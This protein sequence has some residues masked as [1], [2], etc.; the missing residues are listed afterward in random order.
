MRISRS[1]LIAQLEAVRFG[2]S[3][4]NIVEQSSCIVFD[5]DRMFSFNDETACWGPSCLTVEKPLPVCA[6][7]LLGLLPKL[8]D[9]E[10]E[11][12]VEDAKLILRGGNKEFEV[13]GESEL[14]LPIDSVPEPGN[15][16][17]LPPELLEGLPVVNECASKDDAMVVLTMIHFTDKFV[18][19]YDNDQIARWRVKC[20]AFAGGVLLRAETVK[21]I[22]HIEPNEVSVDEKWVFFRQGEGG[23]MVGCRRYYEDYQNLTPLMEMADG[24]EKAVL[25][26]GLGQAAERAYVFAQENADSDDVEVKLGKGVALVTGEGATGRYR[27]KRKI[28]Y[29]GPMVTFRLS[30]T[31]LV[32]LTKDFS[33]C[34]V[35]QTMIR[36]KAGRL[37]Y[38]VSLTKE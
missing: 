10:L 23:V 15:W 28:T 35:S 24:F 4:K 32:K 38:T 8:P 29:A 27:E 5:G 18:E 6:A 17:P 36:V 13:L 12:R 20:P 14:R 33:D 34:Q 16:Q 26:A 3:P 11:V 1:T 9:D 37:T 30:P 31:L 25:P 21:S 19:A 2:V 7:P 22:I